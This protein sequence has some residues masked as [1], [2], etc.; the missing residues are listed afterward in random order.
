MSLLESY[1]NLSSQDR[2]LISINSKDDMERVF[3]NVKE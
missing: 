3:K 1:N 2:F